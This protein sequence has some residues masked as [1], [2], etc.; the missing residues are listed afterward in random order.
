LLAEYPLPAVFWNAFFE[1][2]AARFAPIVAKVAAGGS[3]FA[4]VRDELP[5]ALTRAMCHAL[6]TARGDAGLLEAIRRV[7]ARAAGADR[8][9]FEAWRATPHARAIGSR[10]DEAFWLTVLEWLA[11]AP[12]IDVN[13]VGPL[14]DYIA[15]RRRDD[16][17]FA[18][19]GRSL[20]AMIRAM[21]EWH[22]AL[23]AHDHKALV[24]FRASGFASAQWSD[25]TRREPDGSVVH[26]TWRLRELLSS[27]ALFDE[28]RR[29][30]HC[31]Y[32]YSSLVER[33]I[34]SIWSMTME[35][36]RG[37][38]GNWSMATVEVRNELR[39]VVQA[40]GRHNRALTAREHDVLKR[41]A[42]M[43]GLALSA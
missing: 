24:F 25:L 6:L 30:G 34:S 15:Q 16:G 32:S 33:G 21:L 26:E 7:Q 42:G 27:R 40:R 9:L 23:A 14:C 17:A 36:G 18:L 4:V 28:G 43:N 10:D 19:K 20:A 29:M 1:P 13:Q 5:I 37:P 8:R 12:F 2:E 39:R 35:D 31:V 41:W 3:L 22:G 38:T 11:R